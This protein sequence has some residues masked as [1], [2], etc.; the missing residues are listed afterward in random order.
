MTA[1]PR[2]RTRSRLSKP[3]NT[4]VLNGIADLLSDSDDAATEHVDTFPGPF[5]TPSPCEA[6]PNADLMLDECEAPVDKDDDV[7]IKPDISQ[8]RVQGLASVEDNSD[9]EVTSAAA[10]ELAKL[11][12]TRRGLRSDSRAR[13][14]QDEQFDA[15]TR[16]RPAQDAS[17]RKVTGSQGSES[18]KKKKKRRGKKSSR[19]SQAKATKDSQAKGPQPP[20]SPG[21]RAVQQ[22]KTWDSPP[23][24]KGP[25]QTRTSL[26]TAVK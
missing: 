2:L 19:A 7:D 17:K 20:E 4:S 5:D 12:K 13:Q 10:Y 18:T 16:S 23:R 21:S 26:R 14:D 25:R 8:W 6:A 24:T 3:P 9:V 15:D 11:R 1:Q 22:T